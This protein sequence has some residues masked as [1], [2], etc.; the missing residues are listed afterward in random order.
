MKEDAR[1]YI[2]VIR[3]GERGTG[4]L[5]KTGREKN[6]S[7]NVIVRYRYRYEVNTYLYILYD[8]CVQVLWM[9]VEVCTSIL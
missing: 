6:A 8:D 9:C 7:H 4:W 5:Y 3:G 1:V 2:A